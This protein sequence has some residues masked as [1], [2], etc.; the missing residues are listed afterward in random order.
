M[1]TADD[2]P[3]LTEGHLP[4]TREIEDVILTLLADEQGVDAARFIEDMRGR[5]AGLD[6]DSLMIVEVLVRIET[7]FGVSLPATAMTATVMRSVSGLARHLEGLVL[8]AQQMDAS[9]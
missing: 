5:G 3:G 8:S 1:A 7:T 4:T 9:A 6:V 2:T